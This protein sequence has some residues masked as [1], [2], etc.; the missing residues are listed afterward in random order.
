MPFVVLDDVRIYYENLGI[1]KP[2]VFIHHL[3][4]SFKSWIYQ[5]RY[6]SNKFS[7]I[8]YDLRGHGR[9]SIPNYP[10]LIEQHSKDLKGLL[11]YLRIDNPIIVGHSLGTLIAL[12]YATRFNIEKL[13]LIGALYKAPDPE[14][15]Y[16][17]I[18]I[19]TSFG[20]EALAEYRRLHREFS[21]S[22][23]MNP[24]AWNLLLEIYKENN[25]LGYKYA[26]EGLL[27][28]R[29]YS[30]DLK[31]IDE[32]T[33]LVYGSEDKLSKNIDI[34]KNN[35]NKLKYYILNGYGH[36]LNIEDPDELNNLIFNFL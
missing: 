31:N 16:N 36:F 18:S 8:L 30:R 12:D 11:E 24:V 14:P 21:D 15:Y 29:D 27:N 7:V 17:Y 3:A 32:D 33:L 4:G 2:I 13:I 23:A 20:M 1:G 5:A 6:F 28:A 10:Y 19:A 22:L 34:F 26:V 35:V 9:S 25:P